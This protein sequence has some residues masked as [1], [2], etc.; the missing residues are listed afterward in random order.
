MEHLKT[1]AA[2]LHPFRGAVEIGTHDVFQ[3]RLAALALAQVRAGQHP[4]QLQPNGGSACNAAINR[5]NFTQDG[6]FFVALGRHRGPQLGRYYHI[7]QV[8]KLG[9]VYARSAE[10]IPV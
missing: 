4:V 5:K 10:T 6:F 2:L 1:D 3:Q 7:A 9:Q 8:Y